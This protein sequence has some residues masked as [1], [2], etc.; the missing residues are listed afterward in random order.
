VAGDGDNDILMSHGGFLQFYES[1]GGL[2]PSFASSAVPGSTAAGVVLVLD[3]DGGTVPGQAP[4]SSP[5]PWLLVASCV[6]GC[7]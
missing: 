7:R 4:V 5:L 3:M 1:S 2:V 6:C